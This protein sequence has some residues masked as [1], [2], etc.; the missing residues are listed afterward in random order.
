MKKYLRTVKNWAGL[1]SLGKQ[2][3]IWKLLFQFGD[4]CAPDG[5]IKDWMKKGQWIA[6][7]YDANSCG[8]MAEIA[9]LLGN[10]RDK[11]YYQKL[12]A[13][14][15]DAYLSVFTD[16]NGGLKQEFQTAY[17]LPLYFN[18]AGDAIKKKM[19]ANLTRLVRQRNYHLSTGFTGTPYLL[20]ALSDHG[21]ADTAYKLLMQ[22]SCPSWLYE[23]ERGATTF[24]EQWGAVS[25]DNGARGL[26]I[27]ESD[28]EVSFN[29]Y[30]YGAVGDFL[31][32]RVAG[33]E[34]LSG[35]YK[36]FRIKPVIG[37]GLTYAKG[38]HKT[39]YGTVASEWKISG[40][41]FTMEFEVPVSTACELTLPSGKTKTY[42]S[43]KYKI[44]E[45][46]QEEGQ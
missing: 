43:G 29:H 20:F 13:K 34:A 22:D 7:A 2:R 16:G 41:L 14:I 30:A 44:T 26:A 21:Q 45:S 42:G 36:S 18:M 25:P 4:W 40:G 8:V 28:S 17:V 5:Y 38:R 19:A 33:I 10:E 37:G 3:H 35:G 39:P 31:Y 12:R 32:R 15:C 46:I 27:D 9:G 23:I 6:T 24:W 11:A 1:F